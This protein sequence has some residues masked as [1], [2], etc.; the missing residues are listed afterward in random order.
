[1]ASK[2]ELRTIFF[3]SMSH[4]LATNGSSQ[5]SEKAGIKLAAWFFF[6]FVMNSSLRLTLISHKKFRSLFVLSLM[7]VVKSINIVCSCAS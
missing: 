3:L 4:R 5:P 7:V 6:Y 2:F 1:M